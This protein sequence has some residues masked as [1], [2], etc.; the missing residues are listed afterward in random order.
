MTALSHPQKLAR[1]AA[2]HRARG[3]TATAETIETALVASGRCRICGR[4]L[5]RE[6][7]IAIGIGADCAR[8][9]GLR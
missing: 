8:K 3:D 2:Y 5:A 4:L 6:D 9:L 7:S 1:Q